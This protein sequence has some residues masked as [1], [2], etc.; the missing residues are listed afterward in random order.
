MHLA[1]LLATVGLASSAVIA[2]PANGEASLSARGR[3]CYPNGR[4][5]GDESTAIY[6]M[7][8]ACI[9]LAG[10][11]EEGDI[12]CVTRSLTKN[13]ANPLDAIFRIRRTEGTYEMKVSGQIL[14]NP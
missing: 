3:S 1:K 10:K 9:E 6:H 11:Y 14:L 13:N 12:K 7:R 2:L 8:I 5:W 4:G